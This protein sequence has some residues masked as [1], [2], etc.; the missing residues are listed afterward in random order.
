MYEESRLEGVLAL[1][2]ISSELDCILTSQVYR[3]VYK[4]GNNY[5]SVPVTTAYGQAAC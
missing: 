5:E 3:L 1:I 4:E 2:F